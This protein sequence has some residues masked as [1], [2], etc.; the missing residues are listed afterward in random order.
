MDPLAR[1]VIEIVLV[2]T[3][4]LS[5]QGVVTQKGA[6]QLYGSASNTTKPAT[7]RFDDVEK[8]TPEYAT[9]KSE[10]VRKGTARYELLTAQ[11]HKRI[12]RAVK[13]VAEAKGHDFVARHGDIKDER[14]LHVADLTDAVVEQIAADGQ[15]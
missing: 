8:K 15:T 10:G 11:M 6:A 4:P 1:R 9:I 5:A 7:I 3:A 14:G 2:L 12:S 13:T